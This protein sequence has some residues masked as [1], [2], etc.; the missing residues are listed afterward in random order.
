MTKSKVNRREFLEASTAGSAAL[1]MTAA[2]A[3]RVIGAN[4]RIGI[5][6]L[7][8]GGRCNYAHVYNI[9]KMKGEKKG[10][11]AGCRLRCLGRQQRSG[12]GLYYTAERLGLNVDDKTHVTKDYRQL[13]D[14]KEVDAVCVARRTT[15]TPRCRIDAAAA[16]KHV[17]CEKPMTAPSK[18]PMP[19]SMPSPGTTRV[20]TVGVQSMAD[21][22]WLP[23]NDIIT[24]GEIGHVAQAQTSYYRNSVVGQWRYYKLTQDM[25]PTTIDWDMFLGHDFSVIRRH[26]PRPE[27]CRSTGPSTASGA[28]TG[29]SAAACSPTCSCIRRRT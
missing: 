14:L 26:A 25:T 27:A 24:R 1:T 7:G 5:A 12:R 17:Y 21:P 23:A 11:R 18:R 15:G 29:H 6:F 2:S 9:L 16:G 10:R 19:S 20:M 8:A 4:D 28:A 3:A 13:L 22:T